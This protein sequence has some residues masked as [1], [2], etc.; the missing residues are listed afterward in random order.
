MYLSPCRTVFTIVAPSRSRRYRRLH[1]IT[2]LR[3]DSSTRRHCTCSCRGC[4]RRTWVRRTRGYT[5]ILRSLPT[6]S[7]GHCMVLDS[8]DGVACCPRSPVGLRLSRERR[9][10]II[11]RTQRASTIVPTVSRR[12]RVRSTWSAICRAVSLT[13]RPPHCMRSHGTDTGERPYSCDLCKDTFTRSDTL[14]RHGRKC[15]IRRGNPS[16]ANHL[17]HANNHFENT[18]PTEPEQNSYLKRMS[19]TSVSC[20]DTVYSMGM[21]P[22]PAIRPGPF[23]D[24]LSSI[25]NHYSMSAYTV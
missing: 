20:S 22:M 5:A 18:Q 4:T 11:P 6:R 21:P 16:G 25:A 19:S 3:R 2:T 24:S 7:L 17:Q 12:I 15:S 23:S 14:K 10:R 9:S 1:A 13:P 8:R